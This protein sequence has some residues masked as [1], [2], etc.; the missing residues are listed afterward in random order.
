MMDL[1]RTATIVVVG[2]ALLAWLAGAAT[3]NR[4][5]E[6][7][8]LARAPAIDTRGAELASEIARLHERLRPS[9]TPSQ[10]SRNLFSFQSTPRDAA[11]RIAVPQPALVEAPPLAQPVPPLKLA[12]VAEDPG[13][14]GPVRTAIITGDGQLFTV[15]EGENVT[16]RYRVVRISADVVELLDLGD[17]TVRRLALR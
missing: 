9:A 4:A 15:K 1:K 2:G 13:A 16:T 10:R 5:V 6:P 3:S 7:A 8:P 11:P 17:N 14:D 12:G